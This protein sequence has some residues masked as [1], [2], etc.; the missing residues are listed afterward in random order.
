VAVNSVESRRP[1]RR[2]RGGSHCRVVTAR[3]AIARRLSG[4]ERGGQLAAT[5]DPELGKQPIQVRADRAV[6]EIEALAD[7]AV[8]ETVGREL[9]DLRWASL[10]DEACAV[11]PDCDS[12]PALLSPS[13][14]PPTRLPTVL[15]V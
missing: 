14:W 8:G 12:R 6:R 2:R 7:F 11:A 3:P 5:G 15:S 13:G 4:G 1:D 10:F 9:C